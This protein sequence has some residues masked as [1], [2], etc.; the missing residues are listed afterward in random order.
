MTQTSLLDLF[1]PPKGYFG[2]FGM[3]CGFTAS[4][5]VLDRLRRNFS[6]ET[7]RP[8]LAAFIHP[9]VAAVSDLPGVA[10]I[11]ISPDEAAR[12]Y[13]LLHAKVAILGFRQE[14][15]DGYV[16]R[17]VTTTGNWTEDPL[18]SSIDLFWSVDVPTT[19]ASDAQVRADLHAVWSLFGWLRD[20][21]DTSLI[22]KTYDENLP[23]ALLASQIAAIPITD[24]TP[25]FIDSR[26]EALMPQI[27]RRMSSGRKHNRLFIGSGY[28]EG[29]HAGQTTVPDQVCRALLSTGAL[30]KQA[31]CDIV[32]NPDSCQGLTEK[33]AGLKADGWTLRLP[34]STHHAAGDAKL[35]AKFVLLATDDGKAKCQGHLYL[36]SGNMTSPGLLRPAG[37]AGNLEAG[38]VLDL[39]KGLEWRTNNANAINRYLPI[40]GTECPDIS[41]L[42][43]GQAFERPEEP[44]VLPEVAYLIWDNDHLRAPDDRT[45]AIRK[46]EGTIVQT[47]CSWPGPA[48]MTVT[49]YPDGWRLPVVAD[50]VLVTPRRKDMTVD[51]LLANLGRFPAPE[52]SDTDDETENG[53]PGDGHTQVST[54]ND[55]PSPV[56]VTIYP[57]RR[58][59]RLLV[60]LSEVQARVDPRD[61]PRWCRELQSDLKAIT[62]QE[63]TMLNYF[64]TARVNPLPALA[65]ERMRPAEADADRLAATLAAVSRAWGLADLPSLWDEEDAA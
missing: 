28:F 35:H 53:D 64:R 20:R 51:D 47:P 29:T 44:E 38:I 23:D 7:A 5:Q 11:W 37:S 31:A 26:T 1:L 57:L 41:K 59:M 54:A 40:G 56:P 14:G 27:V 13:R 15:G 9:T 4:R 10:W 16:I 33:A 50:G 61:W 62:E 18:G 55:A 19:Q 12:G 63:E 2:D 21:A 32:L 46:H 22:D 58:M 6:G 43:V 42:A 39:P 24:R 48:P 34:V 30:T 49:T 65:D 3:L 36:G 17:L 25:R 45:I 8:V 52:V 60:R